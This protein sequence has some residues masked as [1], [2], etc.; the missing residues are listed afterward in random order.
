[1]RTNSYHRQD[2]SAAATA[3][4][5]PRSHNHS[6]ASQI[7]ATSGMINFLLLSP[8]AFPGDRVLLDL[9]L[10]SAS[11]VAVN[12]YQ[13]STLGTLLAELTTDGT[14]QTESALL[15]FVYDGADWDVQSQQMP[16]L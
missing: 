9:S 16:S 2:L 1:M 12:V 11:G 14:P 13:D 8:S 10:P 5:V 4:I 15:Q 6:E 3:G 7:T